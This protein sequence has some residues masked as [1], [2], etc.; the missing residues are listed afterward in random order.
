[1]RF[2]NRLVNLS[3]FAS[4]RESRHLTIKQCF[5]RIQRFFDSFRNEY[6]KSADKNQCI[7]FSDKET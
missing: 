2:R 1:M 5:I 6:M 4:K 3:G 7:P